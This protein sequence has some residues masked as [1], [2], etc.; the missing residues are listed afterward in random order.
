[1]PQAVPRPTL[2][3][4]LRYLRELERLEAEGTPTIASDEL[5]AAAG[6]TAHQVRKDLSCLGTL[7]RRGVGYRV[8]DIVPTLRAALALDRQWRVALVGAGNIGR[9]LC[10]YRG[11]RERGFHIVALFDSD[12][13]KEGCTWARL[14]VLP[15]GQLRRTVAELRVE[16][17]IIAVPATAAQGVADQLVAAGVR[18]ILNFAPARIIVPP[19]VQVRSVDL[20]V[21]AEQLAFLVSAQ[22]T[23]PPQP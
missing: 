11:F 7:G 15:M 23:Q 22:S 12:P 13:R 10:A 4:L 14:K 5:G 2:Q 9:A 18:G 3:R 20:A 17:G 1:M 6:T 16:L 8:G 19:G 21:E